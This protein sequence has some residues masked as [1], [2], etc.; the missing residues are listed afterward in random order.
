M[1]SAKELQ[2]VYDT[3][4]GSRGLREEVRISLRIPGKSVLYLAKAIELG[5]SL[6]GEKQDNTLLFGAGEEEIKSIQAVTSEIL[7]KAE[8]AEDYQKLNSFQAK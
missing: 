7:Q 6:A 2:F 8:L 1:L 3:I 4:L 5:I